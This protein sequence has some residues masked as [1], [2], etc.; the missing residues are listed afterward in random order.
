MEEKVEKKV[1]EIIQ[2]KD[3]EI[4]QEKD[5]EIIQEKDEEK[6]LNLKNILKKEVLK[7]LNQFINEVEL[8]FDYIDKRKIIEA[9]KQISKFEKDENIFN[10][11]IKNFISKNKQYESLLYK[12]VSSNS[13]IKSSEF[14]FL[15]NIE[16]LNIKFNIFNKENK[17]TKKTLIKYIYNIYMSCSV[18]YNFSNIEDQNFDGFLKFMNDFKLNLEESNKKE[19]NSCSKANNKK[20]KKKNNNQEMFG[21]LNDLNGLIGSNLTNN[22]NIMNLANEI[23]KDIE[24][25]NIDPMTILSSM[26]SGSSNP[27]VNNLVKNITN[28]LENKINTGEIDGNLLEE[29]AQNMMKAVEDTPF[30][31]SMLPNINL[32]KKS[33]K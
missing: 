27:T 30:L 1:E 24:K 33:K 18:V 9:T 3:E 22:P 5:E 2:E 23:A 8:S 12:I 13:K 32:N 31:Q 28:K 15:D 16:L 4:I 11:F 17:N 25:E 7:V 19:I 29:Q 26:M 20:N 10:E 21:S 6:D 14:E